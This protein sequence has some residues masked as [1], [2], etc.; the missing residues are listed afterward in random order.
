MN[1]LL[2]SDCSA[3]VRK[4]PTQPDHRT[5]T[6]TLATTATDCA[7]AMD[8]AERKPALS[9]L[10]LN[11]SRSPEFNAP[12]IRGIFGRNV[13]CTRPITAALNGVTS[14]TGASTR[15]AGTAGDSDDIRLI[16]S[17]TT[18]TVTAANITRPTI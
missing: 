4:C 6:L 15:N 9:R 12:E 17:E 10:I 14:A 5:R 2:P 11:E 16:T 1:C 7:A 13:A 8:T 18:T 3:R